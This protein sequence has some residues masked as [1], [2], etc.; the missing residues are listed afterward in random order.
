M[1]D[2]SA[3]MIKKAEAEAAALKAAMEQKMKGGDEFKDLMNK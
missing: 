3:D 1:D 2:Q